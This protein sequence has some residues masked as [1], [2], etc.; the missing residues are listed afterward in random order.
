MHSDEKKNSYK[1]SICL[2][3]TAVFTALSIIW[4]L[5]LRQNWSVGI[6][7]MDLLLPVWITLA[8]AFLLALFWQALA[9][10]AAA[11]PVPGRCL[12]AALLL[13]FCWILFSALKQYSIMNIGSYLFCGLAALGVLG[14]LLWEPLKRSSALHKVAKGMAWLYLLCAFG[15]LFFGLNMYFGIQG[16]AAPARTPAL[17]LGSQ[18]NGETPSADLQARIDTAAVWMKQNPQSR[19][20][21]CGGKGAGETISEAACIQRGLI[22]KGITSSRILLDDASSNTKENISNAIKILSN[23]GKKSQALAVITDDY[24]TCRARL[25]AKKAGIAESYPVPSVTPESCRAVSIMREFLA[26]PAQYLT[27]L[28]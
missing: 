19:V 26:L 4:F 7:K 1:D 2:I 9:K 5:K 14:C 11:S 22:K 16:P 23:S 3:A 6:P 8:A 28:I 21:A 18:V 10:A 15:C 27:N 20:V 24:H 17:I 13:F 12:R 25:L